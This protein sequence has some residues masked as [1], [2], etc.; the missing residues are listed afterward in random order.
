MT[1]S[2]RMVMNSIKVARFCAAVAAVLFSSPVN[3]FMSNNSR[4]DPYP[5]FTADSDMGPFTYLG[6]CEPLQNARISASF[7]RQ[8]A[9]SMGLA[10]LTPIYKS[11]RFATFT[12]TSDVEI[13]DVYG[14]WNILA[15]FYPEETASGTPATTTQVQQ[16]LLGLCTGCSECT[17]G[18]GSCTAGETTEPGCTTTPELL[19]LRK[20][21]NC[22]QTDDPKGRFG[23]MSVPILYRKY[24]GRFQIEVG[25]P[26]SVG[27]RAEGS[28]GR[29]EQFAAF[30]DLTS[31]ATPASIYSTTDQAAV[32]KFIMNQFD[33]VITDALDLD[34]DNYCASDMD[35]I[36]FAI[37]W[38]HAFE[39]NN[40][41]DKDS[42]MPKLT[43]V[44]YI[45][46]ECAPLVTTARPYSTLFS[47]PFG[48]DGH[49][50]IGVT[51]GFTINFI[52][53][54]TIG[55]DG[56]M[57]H[58]SKE[59]HRC[60]PVPTNELQIGV[61]PRKADLMIRPGKNF[62]FGATIAAE[63]FWY[64]FST[65]VEFRM[66]NHCCDDIA[67]V[68][69]VSVTN[70]PVP[71]DYPVSNIMLDVLKDRSEWSSSF[72]NIGLTYDFTDAL[73]LGFFWQAPIRQ[74]FTYRSTTLM[75]TIFG[76]F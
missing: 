42:Y 47:V 24:G 57:T 61:F 30:N 48:N 21:C 65:W 12:T 16:Y 71:T 43:F 27:V 18:P 44:P 10:N 58:F 13:G 23:C 60:C 25:T 31:G 36:R 28:F 4:N 62:S 34:V 46:F 14:P 68:N 5:V 38:C 1:F 37:Y 6:E 19:I 56:G 67:L 45:E 22:P 51:A 17:C 66:V 29:V 75:G 41:K 15:L 35:D 20:Y 76:T 73:S 49:K 8:A 40:K 26:Y 74:R 69:M 33:D 11:D 32:S 72:A 54:F 53:M 7:F 50:A 9:N 55:F 64:N 2:K 70:L 39:A 3:G 63:Y 52:D 59:L